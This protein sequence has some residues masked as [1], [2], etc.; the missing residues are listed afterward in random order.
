L[1]L[2]P[3]VKAVLLDL[4]GVVLEIDWSKVVSALELANG[5]HEPFIL[6]S[7]VSWEVYL[8]YERDEI[9][10]E[11]F[12]FELG[13]KLGRSIPDHLFLR[14]WTDLIVGPIEGVPELL[15]KL[16]NRSQCYA[17]SNSNRAHRDY[18]EDRN[19]DLLRSFQEIF[20]S[21]DLKSRKPDRAIFL[22]VCRKIEL[23]PQQILFIDDSAPNVE[24]ARKLG[25][26]A[27]QVKHSSEQMRSLFCSYGLL[28]A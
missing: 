6:N 16:P 17:L 23:P 20:W 2:K 14:A 24:A 12:K 1:R 5:P 28:N 11:E 7:L 21:F 26:Q 25:F 15:Q 4:G 22:K 13:H 27:H 9:T 19:P 3:P 18:L 8:R 10:T